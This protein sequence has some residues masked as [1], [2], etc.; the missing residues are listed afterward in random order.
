EPDLGLVEA[1]AVLS[2]FESLFYRPSEPG[3]ADQPGHAHALALRRETVVEGQLTSAQM[4]AD[5]QVMPR[6]GGTQHP[7]RIPAL[8]LGAGPG[9]A[10][11]PGAGAGEQAAGR[12]GARRR[13]ARR[14]GR[15]EGGPAPQ[16]TAL[17]AFFEDLA[18][19][20]AIAVAL[21][22]AGEVQ[23]GPAVERP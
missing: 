8:P 14:R 7:P 17:A 9:G 2:K 18:Q 22:P 13:D 11:L 10:A 4:A 23:P 6:R 12:L 1:E 5:Q 19:R 21:A 16:H 20:G 3:S 15:G